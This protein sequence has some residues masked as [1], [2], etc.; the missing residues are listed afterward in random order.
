MAV[1]FFISL[2]LTNEFMTSSFRLL[3]CRGRPSTTMNSGASEFPSDRVPEILLRDVVADYGN[4]PVLRGVSLAV[5]K[6][7]SIAVIGPSGSGKSTLL[8]SINLLQ[9]LSSGEIAFRG[10]KVVDGPNQLVDVNSFRLSV[11]MVHQDLNLWPN[12]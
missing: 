1:T 11:G 12:K 3:R 8:R 6:G 5:K 10:E 7:E 9:P 4:G 2:G